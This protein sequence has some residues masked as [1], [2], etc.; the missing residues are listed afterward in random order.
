MIDAAR[1]V[2]V[3]RNWKRGCYN[4]MQGTH[5]VS[6]HSVE[7]ADVSFMVRESGR[8]R[9]L[10]TGRKNVHAYAVGTLVGFEPVSDAGSDARDGGTGVAGGRPIGYDAFQAGH[11]FDRD[12]RAPLFNASRAYFDDHGARYLPDELPQAA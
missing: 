1:P 4:I 7:I 5:V 8:Q 3:F 11:F 10:R 9:M 12:S 2:R 6:A